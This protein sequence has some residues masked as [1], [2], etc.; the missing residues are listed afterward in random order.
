MV[1]IL[2]TKGTQ[3]RFLK[4][5]TGAM[6]ILTLVGVSPS[7][8]KCGQ[9]GQPDGTCC[10]SNGD[11]ASNQCGQKQEGVYCGSDTPAGYCTGG[12]DATPNAAPKK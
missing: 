1:T 3:G 2:S 7:Y 4:F 8:A 10:C 12:S 6:A 5:L 11:C 9:S